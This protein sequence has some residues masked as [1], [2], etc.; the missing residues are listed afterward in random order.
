MAKIG[1][2]EWQMELVHSEDRGTPSNMDPELENDEP[3]EG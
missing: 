1:S 3:T 2:W